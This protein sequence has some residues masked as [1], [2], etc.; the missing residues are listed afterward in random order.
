MSQLQQ[1]GVGHGDHR[2]FTLNASTVNLNIILC[3][4]GFANS[5]PTTFLLDS[6][7]AVSVI[8]FQSL[9]TEDHGAIIITELSPVSANGVS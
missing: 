9:S 7:A 4:D 2:Q 3:T 1:W 6:G 5:L 8:R